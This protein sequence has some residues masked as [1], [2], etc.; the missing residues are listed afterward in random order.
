M[1]K[2]IPFTESQIRDLQTNHPTPFYIYD[3]AAIRKNIQNLYQV[4]NWVPNFKNYFAVKALPNPSI[5]KLL[6]EE[7]CGMDCSSLGELI[8]S[9][10]IGVTGDDIM[11]TSNNTPASEFQKAA[12]LNSIINFDDITHLKFYE[13]HVGTLPETV[14]FRYNPGP[15][16]AGNAI[17]GDPKEAKYGLTK[18]QIFE[19]FA[20]AKKAG[21][22]KFGLHTMVCSNEL[23]PNYFVDTI[24][25]I[26]SLA[27]EVHQ[28]EGIMFDFINIGGGLGIPYLPTEDQ[29]DIQ[30]ISDEMKKLYEEKLI[31]IGHNPLAIV[32][33]LG[34]Y[35]TGPYGYLVTEVVHKKETY[36]SYRG[37]DASM[38]NL[39]RPGLYG[40]YH[41]VSVLGKEHEPTTET[42]DMVGSLCENNDK[43]AIDRKLPVMEVGDLAVIH[44][45]GAHGHAMGFQYNAKLRCAEFLMNKKNDFTMI[46]RA[47]TLDDYFSTLKF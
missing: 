31:N 46:R 27:A 5:M 43:F 9:E 2:N 3:E 18:P 32:M 45:A 28:S 33:E 35:V 20:Y 15:E 13:E 38:G 22:K 47:E 11:F 10:S 7:K 42:Y 25:M 30:K 26:F 14:C 29:I 19:A 40:A 37:V 23:N 17:I 36:K 44:D 16:K 24:D 12:E 1:T 6:A 39:M 21:V 41:H 4:F 8:L 34:R